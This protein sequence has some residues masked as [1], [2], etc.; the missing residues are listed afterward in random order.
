MNKV[1]SSTRGRCYWCCS[2]SLSTSA[3]YSASGLSP[4]GCGVLRTLHRLCS[5]AYSARRCS[6]R[7]CSLIGLIERGQMEA[8]VTL[9]DDAREAMIRDPD[10]MRLLWAMHRL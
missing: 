10:T 3:S 9:S 6:A 1:G 5:W 8:M 4:T 7:G 2:Y